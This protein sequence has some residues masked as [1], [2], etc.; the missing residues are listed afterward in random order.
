MGRDA[1]QEQCALSTCLIVGQRQDTADSQMEAVGDWDQCYCTGLP[2][3]TV[4]DPLM[5][6]ANAGDQ[7][8]FV[9]PR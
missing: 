3:G 4:L 1:Y 9:V 6:R 5:R 8:Q 2:C 7:I